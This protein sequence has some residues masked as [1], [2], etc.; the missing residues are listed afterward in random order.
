M[1]TTAGG[2]DRHVDPTLITAR[3]GFGE[4]LTELRARAGLSIRAVAKLTEIPAATTVVG[5]FPLW[6]RQTTSLRS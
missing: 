6:T 4:A 1:T 2:A 3:G 5:T